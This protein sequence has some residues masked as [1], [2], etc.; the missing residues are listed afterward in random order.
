[1]P[2]LLLIVSATLTTAPA[3]RE[4]MRAYGFKCILLSGCMSVIFCGTGFT[5]VSAASRQKN[6]PSSAELAHRLKNTLPNLSVTKPIKQTMEQTSPSIK[7]QE[8]QAGALQP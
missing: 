6:D 4:G 5:D 3:L 2:L 1:M 8:N 7:A